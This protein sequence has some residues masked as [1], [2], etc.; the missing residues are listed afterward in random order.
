MAEPTLTVPPGAQLDLPDGSTVT[1]TPGQRVHAPAGT[2]VVAQVGFSLP[3]HL[4][5]ATLVIATGTPA[6]PS[7]KSPPWQETEQ[8]SRMAD[9]YST[10]HAALQTGLPG[11][12]QQLQTLARRPIGG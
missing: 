6:K 1:L 2:Y 5:V 9:A 8:G 7:A 3:Q 11:L 4:T 12:R 10:V